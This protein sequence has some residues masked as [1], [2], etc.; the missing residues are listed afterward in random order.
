MNDTDR[1][2]KLAEIAEGGWVAFRRHLGDWLLEA[3][4]YHGRGATMR[5]AIDRVTLRP[6]LVG[7]DEQQE[8]SA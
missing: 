5:D 6:Q 1:L 7:D 2:A 8:A 3:S 4:R